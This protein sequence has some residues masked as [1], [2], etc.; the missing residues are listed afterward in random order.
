VKGFARKVD[1]VISMLLQE[2]LGLH[3]C[4]KKR[5]L[6]GQ[7]AKAKELGGSQ[8]SHEC[9]RSED[10][11]KSPKMT[12]S[13]SA[14]VMSS[15]QK[16]LSVVLGVL[17]ILLADNLLFV[18]LRHCLSGPMAKGVTFLAVFLTAALILRKRTRFG[19][20]RS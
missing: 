20:L 18:L 16:E 15:N 9:L 11:H 6:G 7:L 12:R 8:V 10:G 3:N 19:Y 17:L 5:N 13:K 2:H 14:N 4:S 1:S